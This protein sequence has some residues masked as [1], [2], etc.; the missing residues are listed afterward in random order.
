MA[1]SAP[2][3]NAKPTSTGNVSS[4]QDKIKILLERAQNAKSDMDFSQKEITTKE[5]M[6]ENSTWD[7]SRIEKKK[8][9]LEELQKKLKEL[10]HSGEV[11]SRE[12]QRTQERKQ[13]QADAARQNTFGR[14]AMNTVVQQGGVSAGGLAAG[15]LASSQN[16]KA[17][18]AGQFMQNRQ[19]NNAAAKTQENSAKNAAKAQEKSSSAMSKAANEAA[20][21]ANLRQGGSDHSNW[22]SGS[23]TLMVLLAVFAHILCVLNNYD[24]ST[25]GG[26]I[27]LFCYAMVIV[28]SIFG[29]SGKRWTVDESTLFGVVALC[30]IFP[31]M[32]SYFGN[33]IDYTW[34]KTIIGLLQYFPPLVL[35]LFMHYP[36]HSAGRKIIK[37]YFVIWTIIAV[38]YLLTMS[39]TQSALT[40][41]KSG[42]KNPTDSAKYVYDAI[43][44]MMSKF[45]GTLSFSF[46]NLVTQ[47]TCPECAGQQEN[48]RGIFLENVKPVEQKY[49][50][51]SDVW[52]EA[53]IKA[54]NIK[55]SVNIRNYCTVTDKNIRGNITPAAMNMISDDINTLDCHL[56]TLN[57]G[58]Y[59][60]AITST[61]DFKTDAEVKYYFVDSSVNPQVYAKANIPQ[62]AAPVYTGGPVSL[63]LPALH[64]PLR[65]SPTNQY[66]NVY[67]FGVQLD[68][69]WTEGKVVK[70]K[71]FM[72]EVPSAIELEDCTRN[73]TIPVVRENGRNKYNFSLS[74]ANLRENFDSVT[75]RIKITDPSLLLGTNFE[76]PPERTF[77]AEATYEYMVQGTTLVTVEKDIQANP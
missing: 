54:V 10:G 28:T 8:K 36:E 41:Y 19:A 75:C 25:P 42:I 9:E 40:N 39:S 62:I 61:F 22:G 26:F 21:L 72:L 31:V 2:P 29:V 67:P 30:L 65:I 20:K 71:M 11:Q 17:Q 3:G 37:W 58:T 51:T 44:K 55:E 38:V 18:L 13:Q 64:L 47:A 63:G 60:V 1:A 4:N 73:T 59:E 27:A 70:G 49:Y 24:Y 7:K 57:P 12:E 74:D 68:N 48:Q 77:N 56:G 15:M 14:R 32:F 69:K 53:T 76:Y 66:N 33:N 34:M 45:Y 5:T 50:S 46:N 6:N 52:V 16:P 43:V 35:Y 23:I